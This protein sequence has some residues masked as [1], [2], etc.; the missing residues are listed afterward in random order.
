MGA[1]WASGGP[2]DC[3]RQHARRPG[4]QEP[5]RTAATRLGHI[6]GMAPSQSCAHSPLRRA[7]S[8]PA[9]ASVPVNQTLC[10]HTTRREGAGHGAAS[11]CGVSVA[12]RGEAA[13]TASP[14]RRAPAPRLPAQ[15]GFPARVPHQ[16][17]VYVT[18]G[19]RARPAKEGEDRAPNV[20]AC[21]LASDRGCGLAWAAG[22][23]ARCL[24][25]H[26]ARPGAQSP[27]HHSPAQVPCPSTWAPSGAP[28]ASRSAAHSR[29]KQ[30][31][32][33]AAGRRAGTRCRWGAPPA[34]I[35]APS[36]QS[37]TRARCSSPP[38]PP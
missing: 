18:P 37:P 36:M 29:M 30:A 24:P 23:G 15:A 11:G 7:E 38:S 9:G 34:A 3:P 6:P 35:P 25:L 12:R 4:A 22:R 2:P 32:V 33:H 13:V 31:P 14:R 8:L 19:S 28:A 10:V 21:R 16:L 1:P 17:A 26:P 5:A 20:A 27:D